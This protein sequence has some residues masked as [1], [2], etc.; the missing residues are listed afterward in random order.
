MKATYV[1][2]AA[3]ALALSTSLAD[4]AQVEVGA[5]G[6]QRG[7]WKSKKQKAKD[8]AAKKADDGYSLDDPAADHTAKGIERDTAGDKDAAIKSFQAAA[9]FAESPNTLMNLGVSLLRVAR[10]YRYAVRWEG[11]FAFFNSNILR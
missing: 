9:E 2:L 11:Y 4:A 5:G 7:R 3:L 8:A 10:L 1:L 6:A